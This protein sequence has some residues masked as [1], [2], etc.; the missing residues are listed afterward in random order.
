[1]SRISVEDAR[2]LSNEASDEELICLAQ[3]VRGRWHDPKRATHAARSAKRKTAKY[4]KSAKK[5]TKQSFLLALL[6][7]Q[8]LPCIPGI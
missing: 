4:A 2:G 8:Y 7:V 3:D 6:A 1:M 5:Y